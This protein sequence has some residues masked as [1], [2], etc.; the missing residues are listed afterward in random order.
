VGHDRTI[1]KP[2]H[3]RA[4]LWFL[5]R[6]PSVWGKAV[7]MPG[8]EPIQLPHTLI[9]FAEKSIHETAPSR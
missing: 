4:F 8:K 2:G 6:E 3:G 9:P 7:Q 1:E 5:N